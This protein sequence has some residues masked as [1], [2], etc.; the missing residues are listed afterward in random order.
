MPARA[1][2]CLNAAEFTKLYSAKYQAPPDAYAAIA[3][4]AY[5]EMFRAFEAAKTFEP[6]KVA[7]A[8]KANKGQF[9]T[10]KGPARWRD[11]HAAGGDDEYGDELRQQREHPAE[12]RGAD[13]HE[14][15]H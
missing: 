3:Y 6:L 14:H 13:V 10:V 5:M 1:A 2:Y 15:G 11:D 4:T 9:T 12:L 8:L 7:A